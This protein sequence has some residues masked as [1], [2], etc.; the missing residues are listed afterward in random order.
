MVANILDGK[1]LGLELQAD[2]Q[3]RVRQ[4]AVRGIEPALSVILVVASFLAR[5]TG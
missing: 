2:L 1:A 5:R 3:V 4:L